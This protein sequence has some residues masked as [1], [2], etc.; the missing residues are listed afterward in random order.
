LLKRGVHRAVLDE[1]RPQDVQNLIGPGEPIPLCAARDPRQDLADLAAC[2]KRA[3]K[4]SSYWAERTKPYLA[5]S[6]DVVDA[7][8]IDAIRNGGEA[9]FWTRLAIRDAM[10]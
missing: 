8:M 2:L 6:G 3:G 7:G 9:P 5:R 1:L 4:P 10:G